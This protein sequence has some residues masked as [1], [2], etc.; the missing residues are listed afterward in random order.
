MQS[1]KIKAIA[2]TT[3]KTAFCNNKKADSANKKLVKK[4]TI[5]R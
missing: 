2:F 5:V 3:T 4:I 1:K